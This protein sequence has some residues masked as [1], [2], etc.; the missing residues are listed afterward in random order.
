MITAWAP[1]A[2]R[3]RQGRSDIVGADNAGGP[4]LNA[5]PARRRPRCSSEPWG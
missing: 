3:R 4:Y 2:V 5:A 1:V